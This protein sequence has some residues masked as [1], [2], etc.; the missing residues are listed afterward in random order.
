MYKPF[1]LLLALAAGA[2]APLRNTRTEEHRALLLRDSTLDR[3]LRRE[4][5]RCTGTLRQIVVEY[6]PPAAEPASTANPGRTAGSERT[7]NPADPTPLAAAPAA[8]PSA[9]PSAGPT[10]GLI[11][12]P[13]ASAMAPSSGAPAVRR[14]IR[15]ELTLQRDRTTVTDSLARSRTDTELQQASDRRLRERPSGT[16]V[17]FRRGALLALLLTAG[18]LLRRLRR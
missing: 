12:G 6:A 14:I 9:K 2:C 3:L 5:D 4:A 17:W 8:V 15:T 13:A 16:A 10:A 18:L 11:A 7:E 1:L